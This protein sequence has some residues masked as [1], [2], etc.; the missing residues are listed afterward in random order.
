[1]MKQV[2]LA[3]AAALA[4]SLGGGPA[5]ADYKS[6]I[7]ADN[8]VAY[9]R[10]GEAAAA[11]ASD[12]SSSG[13]GGLYFG[14]VT[15]GIPGAIVGDSDT[16]VSFDG[17]SAHVRVLSAVGDDFSVELWINTTVDSLGGSQCYQ[18]TGLV[19]SDV[20][21]VANDW[22]VG[23]LNDVACFFTGNPDD[24]ITGLT[25]LNDG[26]WHHIVATR[27]LGGDKN[28]YVDGMLENIGSTNANS[29]T[30]NPIVE[31]G[32][33][34]LDRRYFT[35]SIDEVAFYTKVLTPDQILAHYKAGKGQ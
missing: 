7:L 14:G 24:S 1:M 4:W 21:G 8:P 31:I 9:Y 34:T 15:L 20:A 18:G 12:S 33:N 11:T 27:M 25:P 5:Q 19:W 28:L 32:G 35:G 22:I 16:A 13:L 2:F 23:Y 3:L 26:N 30:G 17:S 6:T 10:L 29:L